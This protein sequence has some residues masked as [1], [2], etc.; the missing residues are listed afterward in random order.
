MKLISLNIH[1]DQVNAL[2]AF[3]VIV[4]RYDIDWHV[5]AWITLRRIRPVIDV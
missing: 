3:K 5:A 1:F 2:A 4:Q